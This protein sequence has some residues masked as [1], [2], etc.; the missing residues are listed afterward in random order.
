MTFV[1]KKTNI[2]RYW[3][4]TESDTANT[5]Y[6]ILFSLAAELMLSYTCHTFHV[7]PRFIFSIKMRLCHMVAIYTSIYPAA[8]RSKLDIISRRV[9]PGIWLPWRRDCDTGTVK[10]KLTEWC[11]PICLQRRGFRHLPCSTTQ[12]HDICQLERASIWVKIKSVC[13]LR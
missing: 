3:N 2:C 7:L 5:E 9:D 10:G 1:R 12:S 6:G 8:I 11:V 13:F 4:S